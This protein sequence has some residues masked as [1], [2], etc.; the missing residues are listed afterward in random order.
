MLKKQIT[1]ENFDGD[2]VTETLYFHFSEPEL[3]ELEVEYE[4]GLSRFIERLAESNDE[5]E[6]LAIAKKL[7]LLSYG[8]KSDDGNRFVKS[9][10]LREEFEHSIAYSQMFMEIAT[11]DK[12]A[13]EFI[14]GIVPKGLA[15]Y[16]DEY[17]K[18]GKLPKMPETFQA[19]PVPTPPPF[20][21]SQTS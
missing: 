5:K 18:S 3:M 2:T 6:I 7:V 4:G 16:L 12:K 8:K 21:E 17:E 20:T 19:S 9:D 13:A 1:Y 10:A 14:K 15:K 11:D